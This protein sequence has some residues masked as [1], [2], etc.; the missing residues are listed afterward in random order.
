[1]AN[2]AWPQPQPQRVGPGFQG[3]W[4]PPGSEQQRLSKQVGDSYMWRPVG[5]TTINLL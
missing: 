1:M 5:Y 2:I 4:A 3:K